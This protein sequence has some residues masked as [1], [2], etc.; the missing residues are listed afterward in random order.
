VFARLAF[1]LTG[2]FVFMFCSWPALAQQFSADMVR[3]KPTG[4]ATMKVFVSGDKMRFEAA[5]DQKHTAAVIMNLAQRTSTMVLPDSKN[6]VVSPPGHL[7]A[8]MPF[9]H[10]DDPENACA[11]WEKTLDKP[12]TCTKVGDEM[13]NGRNTVK[14]RGTADNG[15]TGYAWVD[16]DLHSVIKWEGQAGVAELRN[17]QE[18]P[19]AVTLFEVPEGYDQMDTAASK[20]AA[21]AQAAKKAK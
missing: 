13:L 1:R 9:F 21:K 5:G 4:A 8:A 17:I 14:Y 18:G 11:A 7:S 20:K 10:P 6:Y 3:L 2:F 15:D 12:G 19:Q 16:R